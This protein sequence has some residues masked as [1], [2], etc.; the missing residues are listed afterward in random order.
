MKIVKYNKKMKNKLDI[1]IKNFNDFSDKF[2]SIKIEIIPAKNKYGSLIIKQMIALI[3][4]FI[5]MI[6][7]KE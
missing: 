1:D 5:L 2:S 6:M 4:I 3:F 7:I